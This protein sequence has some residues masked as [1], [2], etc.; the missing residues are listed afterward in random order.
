MACLILGVLAK[1]S[2]GTDAGQCQEGEPG[3]LKPK[4]VDNAAKRSSCRLDPAH[5][6]PDR[7]PPAQV[8]RRDAGRN[9]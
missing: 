4:L 5:G 2:E 6:G 7:P 1:S 3:N 9:L 8:I